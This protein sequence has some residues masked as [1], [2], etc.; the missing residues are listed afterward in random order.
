MSGAASGTRKDGTP[1][2]VKDVPVQGS[3]VV[4]ASD[5]IMKRFWPGGWSFRERFTAC[6]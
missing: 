5:K 2:G 3:G 1:N 6:D 4:V